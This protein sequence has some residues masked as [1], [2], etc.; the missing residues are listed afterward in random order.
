MPG[1]GYEE[2]DSC[3]RPSAL[4][5]SGQGWPMRLLVGR[6]KEVCDIT[7]LREDQITHPSVETL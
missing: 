1:D 3:W 6:D 4:I 7:G 5:C 2:Q